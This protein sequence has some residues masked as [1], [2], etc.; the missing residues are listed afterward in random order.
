M[1]TSALT[2]KLSAVQ[3]I[4]SIAQ[5]LGPSFFEWVDPVVTML[6]DELIMDKTSS[7]IRKE[8]T[9]T[10]PT[11]LACISDSEQMKAYISAVLSPIAVEIKFRCEKL[12]F[13]AVK[14]LMKALMRVFKQFTNF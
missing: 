2:N 14:Y 13:G 10:I 11:L 9:K 5:S 12:D 8:A 6:K 4:R 7:Q 3:I 1:N